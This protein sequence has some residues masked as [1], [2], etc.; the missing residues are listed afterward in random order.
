MG[1]VYWTPRQAEFVDA[2]VECGYYGT[3]TEVG[4]AALEKLIRD[5]T[6]HQR[7]EIALKLYGKGRATVSRVAEVADVP[8]HEAREIL[9]EHGLL[10]EGAGEPLDERRAKNR[11][12]AQKLR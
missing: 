8:L 3:Q 12:A 2:L 6:P 11:K 5:L 4:R 7:R 9:R 1:S 10:K